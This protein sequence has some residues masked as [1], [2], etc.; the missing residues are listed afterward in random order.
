MTSYYDLTKKQRTAYRAAIKEDLYDDLVNNS[1]SE[2]TIY[3]SD[4]DT[5]VRKAAYSSLTEIYFE[6][7]DRRE[8]IMTLLEELMHNDD[9][10]VRQTVIFTY[11]QIFRKEPRKEI[12]PIL[13]KAL[14]D[15][16]HK[17]KNA[18]MGAMKQMG[19]KQPKPVIAFAKK[20]ISHKDP[21]IRKR[22]I[23]GI[24]LWGRKHPEDTLPVYRLLQ[25][26]P[27]A[28]VRHM[29]AHV[30]SQNS[31]KEGC[32]EKVIA[33]LK[34]WTNQELVQECIDEILGVHERYEDFS[35]YDLEDAREKLRELQ[36]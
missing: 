3:F 12:L 18:V 25:F 35:A 21:N 13:E 7:E 20:L 19:E 24:E 36:K 8:Q 28:K 6:H 2:I 4:A 11:G 22:V 10:H 1:L 17:V 14:F 29:I 23:H 15:E 33:E 32:L 27:S 9:K 31:Y 26:D 16:H 5:Y 34:T 30:V